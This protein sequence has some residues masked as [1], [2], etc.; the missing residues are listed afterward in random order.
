MCLVCDDTG[1]VRP[2]R[3]PIVIPKVMTLVALADVHEL[4]RLLL[5][6]NAWRRL[7]NWVEIWLR[8]ICSM[9]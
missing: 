1:W 5:Y 6:L 4:M 2:L 3:R 7:L 8:F 9:R